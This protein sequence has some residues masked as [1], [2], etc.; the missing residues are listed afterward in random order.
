MRG[1]VTY[2]PANPGPPRPRIST[3]KILLWATTLQ[4]DILGL[5]YHL[6]RRPA[7]ELMVSSERSEVLGDL[8]GLPAPL[9]QVGWAP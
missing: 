7:G 5:A 2:G 3:M 6:D 4:A 1:V 8:K 9:Q